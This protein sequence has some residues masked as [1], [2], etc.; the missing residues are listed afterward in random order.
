MTRLQPPRPFGGAFLGVLLAL[1][2]AFAAIAF[3]AT[4]ARA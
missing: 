1:S 2:A 4:S 3:V